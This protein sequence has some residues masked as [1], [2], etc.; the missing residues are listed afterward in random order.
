MDRQKKKWVILGI[1]TT[2][3]LA[4]II[5]CT[6]VI[7]SALN[8]NHDQQA[9]ISQEVL[10][11][12]PTSP[13]PDADASQGSEDDSY[14]NPPDKL[15]YV[16]T[17]TVQTIA[18]YWQKTDDRVDKTS[19]KAL[20]GTMTKEC[21]ESYRWVWDGVFAPAHYGGPQSAGSSAWVTSVVQDVTGSKPNRVYTFT[22][23]ATIHPW[24]WDRD[25]NEVQFD[26]EEDTWTVT[27][28]EA[29]EKV[30][31]IVNPTADQLGFRVPDDLVN[32]KQQ[33]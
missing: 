8:R 12:D 2:V 17:G 1:T 29:T 22:V 7:V 5:S 23:T 19:A 15:V 9:A 25:M 28:D 16:A 14:V 33:Q 30:T 21:A 6:V 11:N 20:E 3:V 4:V 31:K 27:V 32:E 24:Y 18:T 13:S 10:G 26:E